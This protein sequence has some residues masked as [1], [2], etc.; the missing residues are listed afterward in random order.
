MAEEISNNI[1][2]ILLVVL[3]IVTSFSACMIMVKVG[4]DPSSLTKYHIEERIEKIDVTCGV[5]HTFSYGLE[6]I[7]EDGIYVSEYESLGYNY[8]YGYLGEN[9]GV[10]LIKE[11]VLVVN[12]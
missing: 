11:K 4:F 9:D 12:S 3:I 2:A 5:T 7:C 10:C 1:L 8:I 6:Y